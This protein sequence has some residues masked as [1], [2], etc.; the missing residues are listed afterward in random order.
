VQRV[1]TGDGAVLD[2]KK[3][4]QKEKGIG[5]EEGKSKVL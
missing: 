1:G 4:A 5:E 3:R 2:E